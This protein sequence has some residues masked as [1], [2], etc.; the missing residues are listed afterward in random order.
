MDGTNYAK[1]SGLI[2]EAPRLHHQSKGQNFYHFTLLSPRLSG[3]VDSIPVLL[4]ER[5]LPS[6]SHDASS[7]VEI[8]GELRSFN[9]HG[10]TGSRLKL[11]L[12]PK[13]IY[14]LEGDFSNELVL[15]GSICKAPSLRRT[16][17][18]RDICDIL[19][20]VNRKYHRADYLPC[21]A[22]GTLASHCAGLS[23]GDSL[24]FSGR[25]QSRIYHKNLGDVTEERRALEVSVMSLLPLA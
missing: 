24:Y 14:P 23:V 4:P 13:E 15:M 3:Q 17:L 20:A 19:L 2:E 6:F 8:V 16:P 11:S 7:A 25:L 9:L 5:L 12:F 18:G 21:I 22:W 1:I 10:A